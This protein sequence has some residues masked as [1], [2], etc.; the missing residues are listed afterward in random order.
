MIISH[1]HRFIF[2]HCRKAAGSSVAVSLSRYLGPEDLQFSG[3]TDGIEF[4]IRPP[5][6]VLRE[7]LASASARELLKGAVRP[8]KFWLAI[9]NGIK[10][11]YAPLLGESAAHPPASRVR[12]AF[13]HE[14]A[15]YYKFCIV[16]NP[17]AKTV[18][19]YFWRTQ[20]MESP[21]SFEAYL[22]ALV[23]GPPLERIT[24]KNHDNWPL[25]TLDDRVAVDRVVRFENLNAELGAVLQEIGIAW[26]DWLP[27]AKAR[28]AKAG[29][30]TN[31]RSHYNERTAGMVAA[32]YAREIAEFGYEY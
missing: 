5:R 30:S 31:Y 18:S 8:K 4:G 20:R 3:I 28:T 14:W 16:R 23:S 2:V 17:W 19:D 29:G 7:G 13:P 11:R 15:A 26:D 27:H 25:Y 6:R 22:D 10:H 24:P 12:Q 1:K 32:L 9:S 21:P